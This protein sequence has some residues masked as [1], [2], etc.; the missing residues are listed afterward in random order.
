MMDGAGTIGK[1]STKCCT[2]TVWGEDGG[3]DGLAIVV[4]HASK[5]SLVPLASAVLLP[6]IGS[7]KTEDLLDAVSVA[8]VLRA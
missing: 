2:S 7:Q 4:V 5:G 3:L 8:L 1:T 6:H